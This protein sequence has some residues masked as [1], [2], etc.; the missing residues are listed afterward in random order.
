MHQH[1]TPCACGKCL[2]RT[3]FSSH[4]RPPVAMGKITSVNTLSPDT[5]C[6]DCHSSAVPASDP[7]NDSDSE[8]QHEGYS[9]RIS[10][11]D[12]PACARKI[13]TAVGQLSAV[14]EGRVLF[15]TQKLI[16]KA[17]EDVR[18][19]VEDAV[20]YA[21]FSLTR[22]GT[23]MKHIEPAGFWR[24]NRTLI[25]FALL[26]LA[27]WLIQSVS[28]QAG[29]VAFTLTTLFG[30]WPTG[31]RA[32]RLIKSGSPF[33]IETLMTIAASGALLIG[34]TA[35][36]ATVLILYMLG[37]RLEAFAAGRARRGVNALMA[38]Q[39]DTAVRLHGERRETV[40]VSSLNPG[41]IIEVAPGARLPAD[42]KLLDAFASFD[43]S[44]LTGESMPVERQQGESISAG[45]L[46]IDRPIR[47]TVTSK[48][49]ESAIDR[50]LHLIEQ[51]EERRA[52]IAR[53][54]D[55]FSRIY[56]PAI[57]ALALLVAILPPLLLAA[58]WQPWI[59]KGLTLLLIGCP[60]ALVISTPAAITSALA[61]ATRR[62][63]LIK[64]GA[65]LERLS[66]IRTIA[67][68][69]TGTLT[70]GKPVVTTLI[71]LNEDDVNL[72]LAKAAAVETGSSHPLA[73]AIVARAAELGL[74]VPLVSG[75]KTLTGS[76][77]EAIVSGHKLLI[78]SP[79]R[80]PQDRLTE[81]QS[82]QVFQ[83]ESAGN[84]VVVMLEDNQPIGLIA[85]RD[86]LR[87]DAKAAVEE[88]RAMNIHSI[89]LTGDN[90]RAAAAIA[91]EL[92][93]DYR[94]EL[95]PADK[96]AVIAGLSQQPLAMVGDGIN[97]APAMKAATI[98]IAMGSGSDVA[99][100][101]ADAALTHNRLNGIAAMIRLS[102]ATHANI[103]QNITIA[104]GLKGI[105]LLTT[106]LGFT[107][108][109]LAVLADSGATA[110]VTANALRLL[111]KN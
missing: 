75:Q 105:F 1:A 82:A 62:G 50:I 61:A 67:F 7:D 88:L 47:L 6:S 107:G 93:I 33:A 80:L 48:P 96:V 36:A 25:L 9:W 29:Q 27:S 64:G 73:R 63:A 84:T 59:Y 111:R 3:T 22:S 11:M 35:E 23:P 21:G 34:A 66:A 43:E 89:M 102:R 77:V 97:D 26:L 17:S 41:D 37:E 69:K 99:L 106:L 65:A 5:P 54:L 28:A 78:I 104:L 13:E 31:R 53:F 90:A 49:G 91:S 100:E 72:L 19:Q 68:D 44:A 60:C 46:S 87:E 103:R 32:F 86:T 108:L 79:A 20:R 74:N 110:L 2:T 83:L 12:C 57:M 30:L 101:A 15:A 45:C 38:L 94:A 10:G 40:A 92:N 58:D 51:A 56:T 52:P 81:Q 8:A 95:L 14:T 109:W 24:E 70:A 98:G 85:L 55:R 76:G 16:V 42:A 18:V 71:A 39:P 4:P